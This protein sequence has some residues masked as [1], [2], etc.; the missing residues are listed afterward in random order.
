MKMK[1][2]AQDIFLNDGCGY[3]VESRPYKQHLQD[4]SESPQVSGSLCCWAVLLTIPYAQRSSCANHKAVN[5][6]NTNRRNLEATG[7]GACAC[8]RHGCFV[9]HS[10]VDFQKG[11]RSTHSALTFVHFI[12]LQQADEH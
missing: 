5:H 12:D 1:Q 7:V 2:P 6:A 3:L 11:E 9:P 4:S 10:V 8:A